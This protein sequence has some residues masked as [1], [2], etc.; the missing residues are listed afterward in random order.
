MA[1]LL[2]KIAEKV[3]DFKDIV[4]IFNDMV[5]QH[6][7]DTAHIEDTRLTPFPILLGVLYRYQQRTFGVELE[8]HAESQED[9]KD[10]IEEVCRKYWVQTKTIGHAIRKG[11]AAATP[12][13]LNSVCEE[14]K[15]ALINELG[16]AEEDLIKVWV[17]EMQCVDPPCGLIGEGDVEPANSPGL[18]THTPDFSITID[19]NQKA[20]VITLLGTRIFPTPNIHDVIMDLRAET[21]PFL[22]GVGHAGMVIGT[23]NILDKSFTE[24]LEALESNPS[25][26]ILVVGYSLG[27]GLAQL[28]AAQLLDGEYAS[29]LPED[30]KIRALCYGAPPVYRSDNGKVFDE[31]III[32]NDKDGI[33][34]ASIRTINDLFNKVVAI[35]A[36][37]IDQGVMI[38]MCLEKTKGND[39]EYVNEEDTENVGEKEGTENERPPNIWTLQNFITTV[40]RSYNHYRETIEVDPAEWEKV[41]HALETRKVDHSQNMALLGNKVLQMKNKGGE[42]SI[43]KY[44]GL[45]STKKFSH[46]IR[47]SKKM[48]GHHMP[49]GYSALFQTKNADCGKCEPDISCLDFI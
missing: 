20:V 1:F 39:A 34:S 27:A 19:S 13:S 7:E 26:S 37:D 12:E 4:E 25:F 47:L 11:V 3:P 6:Q 22:D 28:Y 24:V 10:E 43:K 30:T 15:I 45:E 14:N 21:E 31:I 32:Q 44:I 48:F 49:W 2:E 16:I 40:S 35:D 41:K 18:E 17:S 33:I 38:N 8:E 42:I 5:A 9:L 23:K 29:Q 36:A 46:E